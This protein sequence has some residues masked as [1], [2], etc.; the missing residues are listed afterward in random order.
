MKEGLLSS[1]VKTA[2][3]MLKAVGYN[4]GEVDG[5]FDKVTEEAVIELQKDLNIE[6]SGILAGDSTTGLMEKLRTKIEE[7]DPQLLKA[8]ELLLEKLA[9]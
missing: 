6:P 1:T 8:K 9:K 7:D 2:E 3:E 4:P 5:L